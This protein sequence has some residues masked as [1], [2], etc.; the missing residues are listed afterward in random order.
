MTYLTPTR[1]A[2][3]ALLA[4][5]VTAFAHDGEHTQGIFATVLHWLSSPTHSLF[6]VIGGAALVVLA[7]AIARKKRA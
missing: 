3:L 4:S 7:Y 1:L 6:T 5:P 2:A